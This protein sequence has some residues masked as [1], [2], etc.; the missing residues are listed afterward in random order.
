MD[1]DDVDKQ[2]LSGL[3]KNGRESLTSM[4]ERVYKGNK[5][6]MSHT[7]ISKRITKLE[8]SKILKIQGNL[9]IKNLEFHAAIILLEMKNYEELQK[10]SSAYKDCPRIFLL[11]NVSGR[12]N[13]ILGI[14]G[15]N[16]DDLQMYINL[17]GPSNKE[18]VLHTDILHIGNFETPQFLPINLFNRKS[19]E[20]NCGNVCEEC[21]AFLEGK[22]DGC[23][24][25]LS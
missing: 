1:L 18:G 5:D 10:I 12:Y 19:I 14:V 24:T 6:P 25:F 16:V 13:L 22:C 21:E 4:G 9:N 15:K 2:I 17:C 20:S 11:A 8:D 7:G 3:F 23:G